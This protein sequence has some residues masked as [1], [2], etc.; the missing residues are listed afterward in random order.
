MPTFSRNPRRS[1]I[2]RRMRRAMWRSDSESSMFSSH[3]SARRA[4]S[5]VNSSMRMPA[6][7]TER[8]SARRRAPSHTG[9]AQRHVLLDPLARPLRVGF[10]VALFE[11][12]DHAFEARR[13]GAPAPVAVAVGDLEPLAVGAV[14]EQLAVRKRE[15]LPGLLEVDAVL[16]GERLRHLLVVVRDAVGPRQ[17]HALRD[18][19]RGIADHELRVDLHLRAEARAMRAGAVRGVEREDARLELDER[20]SVDGA[21]EALREAEHGARRRRLA[22]NELVR[23]STRAERAGR[24]GA[25]GRLL[26]SARRPSAASASL[27]AGAAASRD[28]FESMSPSARPTAVSI[29]SARR[30]RTSFRITRRSTTTEMSCL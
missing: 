7:S 16:L 1:V 15:L 10:A 21:R 13:V 17:D 23:R 22:R 9:R 18:R 20:W 30:L 4:E 11:R 14:Q 3:S 26:V 12:C 25:H 27:R 2:S 19:V 29:E 24:V 5:A 6:T 28:D 8:D